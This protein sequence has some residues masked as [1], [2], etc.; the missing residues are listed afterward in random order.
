MFSTAQLRSTLARI[1]SCAVVALSMAFSPPATSATVQYFFEGVVDSD[2]DGSGL[3]TFTG[4]LRF[5]TTAVDL[6]PSDSSAGVYGMPSLTG[7]GFVISFDAQSTLS[8]DATPTVTVLNDY[9][10]FDWFLPI[11]YS[12][13]DPGA[14][15]GFEWLDFEANAFSSDSL[16][17]AALDLSDFDTR[18]LY[19]NS[20]SF[21]LIGRITGLVC[22]LGCAPGEEPPDSPIP[23]PATGLL[24]LAAIPAAVVAGRRQRRRT[25]A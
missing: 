16:P 24:V 6:I 13:A 1:T 18:N 4:I 23:S 21:G 3:Q 12:S 15:L 20:A 9:A 22:D 7:L 5:E 8:F 14:S 17:L 19:F 2:P 25:A 10:G 11:A